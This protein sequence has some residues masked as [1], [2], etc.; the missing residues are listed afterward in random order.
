LV[1]EEQGTT[2]SVQYTC[3]SLTDYED[4]K[5]FHAPRLQKQLADK[6]GNKLVA[7]RTLLEIV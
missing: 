3:N 2:F 4:Y 7:F 6:Y 5:K 1:N